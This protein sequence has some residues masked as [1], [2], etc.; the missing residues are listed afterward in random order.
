M[1]RKNKLKYQTFKW[2]QIAYLALSILLIMLGISVIIGWY[3]KQ[4]YL[5]QVLPN[6]AP[7]QFNTALGFLIAGLSLIFLNYLKSLSILL[8]IILFLLGFITFLQYLFGFNTGLDQ[9][10][11]SHYISVKTSHVG[12]MAPN[13]ALCFSLSAITLFIICFS[14]RKA[15][16]FNTALVIAILIGLLG[17]SALF[18]YLSGIPTAYGWGNLTRMAIHTSIGFILIAIALILYLIPFLELHQSNRSYFPPLLTFLVAASLFS[19]F[20]HVLEINEEEKVRANI[21]KEQSYINEKVSSLL[22]S[23]LD[24]LDRLFSRIST[25]TYTTSENLTH[26]IDDYLNQMNALVFVRFFNAKENQFNLFKKDSYQN[27]LVNKLIVNCDK[28]FLILKQNGKIKDT[29]GI[30]N[31]VCYQNQSINGIAVLDLSRIVGTFSK[32]SFGK[33]FEIKIIQDNLIIYQH[34]TNN[35]AKGEHF[36]YP[37]EVNNLKWQIQLAPDQAIL[38][39]QASFLP[40]IFQAFGFAVALL[41]GFLVRLWQISQRRNKALFDAMI[42]QKETDQVVKTVSESILEAVL[43]VNKQGKIIFSNKQMEKLTGLNHQQLLK[44]NVDQLIP[45]RYRHQHQEHREQYAKLP[46]KR[47]MAESRNI[48]LLSQLG[49]EIPV[50]IALT[51]VEIKGETVTLCAVL[52][53]RE[54]LEA[55]RYKREQE[56]FIE[57]AVNAIV[58]YA[59]IGL[60]HKGKITSWNSGAKKIKGYQKDEIIGKHI[61]IFYPEDTPEGF[62]DSLLETAKTKGHAENEGW[63]KKKDGS[64]FWAHVSLS[65]LYDE[66][67]NIRGFIKITRDLTEKK[68][69]EEKLKKFNIELEKSNTELDDFAYIASH[70]LKQPLRGISNY[71]SFLTEDYADKLDDEGKKQ[72]QT[73]Q[74]LA[75]RMENL[76][77][78]LL[79]FSRVGRVDFAMT[80][81]DISEVIENKL[82]L[83]DSFIKENNTTIKIKNKMPTIVCDHA[84]IGEVFQNLITNA[85]KYNDN[86]QK[87]ITIDYKAEKNKHIFSVKDNG[88]GIAKEYQDKIFKIFQRL[89]QKN[90]Y[91][92]GTGAGMTIVKKIVERHGGS[93]WL[94]SEINKG[95]TFY[96]SISQSLKPT[97]TKI[98][99]FDD[100]S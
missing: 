27:K 61:S 14:Y 96:F 74:D 63:R 70:D 92:G 52:D 86:D 55:K 7:M 58:D 67:K 77:D 94:E 91:G 95:S 68:Q 78:T 43:I 84:K 51:P 5:I 97:D 36:T 76:I 72:L 57:N 47:K 26:D 29:T 64:L 54:R 48:F 60:N 15:T 100:K 50:E 6:F 83:L 42:R 53:I 88:I 30:P 39:Q 25:D 9:L 80:H 18:G 87:E 41:L 66:N 32:N 19:L 2:H 33:D 1:N 38:N 75:K 69:Q 82:L 21:E 24:A 8:S 90:E 13:T 85:I 16:N 37:L 12:R 71:A 45:Q 73:L 59:I 3:T 31:Y 23:K 89:H 46:Q 98:G 20:W 35:N 65:A 62:V 34:L 49:E 28:A 56:E 81:C 4:I 11:M 40:I 10:F 44:I 22:N 99:D 79:T 17:T 93:I